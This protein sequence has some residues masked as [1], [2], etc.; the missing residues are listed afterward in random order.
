M[1]KQRKTF[2]S[3]S[4]ANQDFALRLARELKAE[5]FNIWLD[6]LDIPP[7]ARW[8]D[9]LEKAL[10]TCEIFMVI[11][12]PA[13]MGS[14]DV[15]DEIGYAIDTKKRILPVLLEN[16]TIPLRLRRF[17]HVDFIGK[18]YDQGV[19][20]AIQLLQALMDEPTVPRVEL[21]DRERRQL[22]QAEVEPVSTKPVQKKPISKAAIYGVS[23]VAVLAVGM[24]LGALLNSRNTN[25]V[26]S[27]PAT[28][29]V[30]TAPVTGAAVVEETSEDPNIPITNSTETHARVSV[31]QVTLY[32]GPA[33][34]FPLVSRKGYAKDTEFTVLGRNNNPSN[35]WL[36]CKAP[37]G[38]EGWLYIEWLDLDIDPLTIPTA[39]AIP[40]IP[41]VPTKIPKEQGEPGTA[42]P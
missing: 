34:K 12:T 21:S 27:T 20:S 36:L 33:L 40:T 32:K 22:A 17:Q 26:I 39:S 6:Q 31:R 1:E 5:G 23:A 3:Y 29:A 16:A 7:G 13:S 18:S 10:E 30:A 15:K 42:Y 35:I 38:D 2:L 11:L 19:E 14:K 4:R 24:V 9:E 25:T 8:D 28:D 41:A 37:D